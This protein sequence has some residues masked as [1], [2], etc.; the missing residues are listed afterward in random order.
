MA[1]KK[2]SFASILCSSSQLSEGG[3]PAQ[4]HSY[5]DSS[6]TNSAKAHMGCKMTWHGI[7]T[8]GS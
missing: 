8:H 1:S 2:E 6:Y 4:C 7:S 3:M 5:Y